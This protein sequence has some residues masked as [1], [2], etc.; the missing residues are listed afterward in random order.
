[1]RSTRITEV[2]KTNRSKGRYTK[3]H[4]HSKSPFPGYVNSF[5]SHC[6]WRSPSRS[7]SKDIY[8]LK[9]YWKLQTQ[10]KIGTAR[11]E[12]AGILQDWKCKTGG[13][14]KDRDH[15]WPLKSFHPCSL[16]HMHTKPFSFI[17]PWMG[18]GSEGERHNSRLKLHTSRGALFTH[19]NESKC[20]EEETGTTMLLTVVTPANRA[21]I[22]M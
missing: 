11:L 10:C 8:C 2:V 16:E 9:Y 14:I 17:L 20:F 7:E 22:H 19:P 6:C 5:T 4:F 12:T 18:G 3:R 15:M 1:M 13:T 21:N